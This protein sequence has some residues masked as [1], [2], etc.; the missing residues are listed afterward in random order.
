MKEVGYIR[1]L[2]KS[3]ISIADQGF[4]PKLASAW[5]TD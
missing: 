1:K 4:L 3:G 5:G 2:H